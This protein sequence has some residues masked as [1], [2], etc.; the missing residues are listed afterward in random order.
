MPTI[1]REIEAKVMRIKLKT[2]VTLLICGMVLKTTVYGATEVLPKGI[3]MF[4]VSQEQHSFEEIGQ[5][6]DGDFKFS[7]PKDFKTSHVGI[8]E[9]HK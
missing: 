2:L 3:W 8:V 5:I 6:E 1:S 7:T 4:D 9:R